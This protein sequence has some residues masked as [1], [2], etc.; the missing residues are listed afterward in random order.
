MNYFFRRGQNKDE[1]FSFDTA[2]AVSNASAIAVA[3][4]NTAAVANAVAAAV[5]VASIG[6]QTIF[7]KY[8]S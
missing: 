4:A 2:N 7:Q 6:K 1:S 3:G 8:F 5:A